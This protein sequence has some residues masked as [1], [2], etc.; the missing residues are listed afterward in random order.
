LAGLIA[1]QQQTNGLELL[2]IELDHVLALDNLPLPSRN[3]TSFCAAA[4]FNYGNLVVA[5]ATFTTSAAAF[6]FPFHAAGRT[7]CRSMSSLR[8]LQ[9]IK[10]MRKKTMSE[11]RDLSYYSSLPYAVRVY[12]EPDG[13][14]FTAEIPDLP[15]YIT[16]ADT[17]DE[18]WA[19]I[20]DAKRGWRRPTACMPRGPSTNKGHEYTNES[21]AIRVFVAAF[22]DGG[23]GYLRTRLPH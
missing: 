16:C 17:L 7:C 15:G 4:A 21:C 18:V 12:R 14:G 2:P 19:L 1:A 6:R 11:T 8:W 20:D 22:V 9:S 13:S 3:W 10:P 5:A 23:C